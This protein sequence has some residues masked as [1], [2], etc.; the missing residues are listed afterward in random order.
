MS[1]ICI[2]IPTY[3]NDHT[4]TEVIDSVLGL[5]P[6]VIVVNDGSTDRT[7]EVLEPYKEKVIILSYPK[8]KGK[9]HALKCGFDYAKQQGYRYVLTIDS[10][11]QH[12][13]EDIPLF[14][15]TAKSN[16][17]ALIIGNRNLKQEF[18]PRKNTFANRFSNFWFT[19]QTGIKLPDTQ[20][21]YR[22]YPLEQMKNIRPF[23]SRFEAELELLVR[24]AWSG[25]RIVS[26][27]VRVYYAPEGERISHFRPGVDFFRISLLNTLFV[28]LAVVYG[29]PIRFFR[30]LQ[31][32]IWQHSY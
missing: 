30:Y 18:M 10:D 8:N 1:D 9:G 20:S 31:K 4:L 23:T 16:P 5:I 7:Q 19:L 22:L 15:E 24:C 27:P 28:F 26:I 12:D 29:Y 2:I 11:R 3:N 13:A 21:G 14:I 6:S 32:K 17:E 25:I